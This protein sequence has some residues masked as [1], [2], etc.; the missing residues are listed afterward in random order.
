MHYNKLGTTS[1]DISEIGLGTMTF[2]EQTP[3]DEAFKIMDYAYDHGV[4][5]LDTSEMYPVYPK[6]KTQGLSEII[7]GERIKSKKIRKKILIGTKISSSHPKGIGATKLSWIRKGGK[8]LK[9]DKKNLTEA[10]NLSLKRLNTDYIDLYQLH[11]PERNIPI[12]GS[13]DY[14]HDFN[15]KKWTPIEEVLSHLNELIKVGKIR[16]FGVSNESPWGLMKF[17]NIAKNKNLKL[18]ASIQNAYNLINRVF[19]ISH[20]EISMREKCG[21]IAYSPLASGRLTGKYLLGKKPKNSRFMLWPGRFDRHFTKRGEEAIKRYMKLAKEHNIKP[22][23]LAHAYVLSRPFLTSSIFGATSLEQLK[24]NLLA[25]DVKLSQKII[26]KIDEIHSFD[27]N[28][29]V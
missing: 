12:F 13:L 14:E 23:I 10:I 25:K 28:P 24:E 5:F 26:K 4:N 15:E 8:N 19:D 3:K 18:P 16:N 7:I 11:W 22:N 9:F 27:R 21:L 20:S 29:C 1:I 2:G 6:K 17:I